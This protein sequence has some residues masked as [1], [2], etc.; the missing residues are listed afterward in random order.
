MR[1]DVI[2]TIFLVAAIVTALYS[3]HLAGQYEQEA[4]DLSDK[5]VAARS[6]YVGD[7]ANNA[8]D[9]TVASWED[10]HKRLADKSQE[11]NHLFTYVISGFL[12]LAISV[13]ADLLGQ[14]N[15][16]VPAPVKPQDSQ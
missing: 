4:R 15:P 5:I 7:A 6:K 2:K 11:L 16:V 12:G 1:R 10:D 9:K 3:V 13:A 8:V 14:P